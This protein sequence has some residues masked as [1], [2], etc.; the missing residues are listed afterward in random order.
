MKTLLLATLTAIG[1]CF[2][3]G[4]FAG[5]LLETNTTNTAQL[6]Y[7]KQLQAQLQRQI[8]AAEANAAAGSTADANSE[9]TNSNPQSLNNEGDNTKVNAF[10]F[11]YVDSALP[12]F[13]G[14]APGELNLPQKATALKLGFGAYADQSIEPV[15]CLIPY[16]VARDRFVTL[17]QLGYLVDAASAQVEFAV[18]AAQISCD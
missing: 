15:D 14:V 5:G 16:V 6:N 2:T 3:S 1:I 17:A 8:Q 9:S 12:A 11:S 7:M 10:S 18:K 13:P 4:A